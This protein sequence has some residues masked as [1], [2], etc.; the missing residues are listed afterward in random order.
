MIPKPKSCD[1]KWSKMKPSDKGRLCTAC[2]K[3]IID[4]TKMSWQEI[5]T[6]QNQS[7][8]GVCGMY[9][10]KQL[11][12]WGKSETSNFRI[13]N[14]PLLSIFATWL[15]ITPAI[16]ESPLN[17]QEP[18]IQIMEGSEPVISELPHMNDS[19]GV[20]KNILISGQVMDEH[21]AVLSF[22]SIVLKQNG[23]SITG[24]IADSNGYFVLDSLNL[25]SNNALNLTAS[26]LGYQAQIIELDS[27]ENTTGLE[28][29]LKFDGEITAFE[30]A[31]PRRKR[32]WW[33]LT[34]WLRN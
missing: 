24:T 25:E 1:Q 22:T 18:P 20:P 5:L 32:F 12:N 19:I 17:I 30:V 7:I 21:G 15:A 26:F 29:H 27:L 34:G 11:A 9:T 3:E 23:V 16:A 8:S 6:I 31:A 28:I 2:Q 14:P 33:W 4:F 10:P 13:I